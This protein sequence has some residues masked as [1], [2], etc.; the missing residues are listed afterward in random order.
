MHGGQGVGIVRTDFLAD[1]ATEDVAG[2]TLRVGQ[3]VVTVLDGVVGGA[4]GSVEHITSFDTLQGLVGAGLDTKGTGAA[5]VGERVVVGIDGGVGHE[6]AEVAEAAVGGAYEEGVASNPAE[7][8]G[9][10][11]AFVGD[12]GG[13]DEGTGIEVGVTL[14]DE[15]NHL[16]KHTLDDEVVVVAVGVACDFVRAF[17]G[18]GGLVGEQNGDD[19]FGAGVKELGVDTLVGVALHIL[20]IGVVAV[21]EPSGEGGV[22]VIEPASLSDAAIVE[23]D[24]TGTGFYKLTTDH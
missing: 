12:R 1:V 9:G 6:F 11:P 24:G 16:E 4:L 15:S 20:H 23:A 5:A 3:G 13:I 17:D 8:G 22:E 2:Q 7:A 10:S 18:A 14:L 19:A 21:G